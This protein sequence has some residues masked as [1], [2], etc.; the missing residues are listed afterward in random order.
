M[1]AVTTQTK[2]KRYLTFF[3]MQEL[4]A[5]PL[6]H[7]REI[8]EFSPLTQLPSAPPYIRGVIN[9]RGQVLPVMDLALRF[10]KGETAVKKFSSIIVVEKIHPETGKSSVTGLLVD[11]VRQVI[12]MSE[13]QIEKPPEF[14]SPVDAEYLEGLG[15]MQE[16]FVLILNAERVVST[17]QKAMEAAAGTLAKESAPVSA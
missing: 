3:A 13:D 17:G 5:L 1:S 7:L 4:C 14:G 8:I 9:L 15:R 2:S 10:G 11:T 16:K 6:L 12:S